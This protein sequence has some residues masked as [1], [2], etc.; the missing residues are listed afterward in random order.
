MPT[1]TYKVLDNNRDNAERIEI[2]RAEVYG[3]KDYFNPKFSFFANEITLGKI[4]VFVCEVDGEEVAACYAS[5]SFNTLYIDYLFVLPKYQNSG[6]KIGRSLLQF[7]LDNKHLVEEYF[8]T[9]F[10]FSML[11]PTTPKSKSLYEKVGYK[12]NNKTLNMM[13]KKI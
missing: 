10:V 12:V 9:N 4:L 3:T 8:D 1:I 7:V 2:M 11:S 13:I 5:K 6:L